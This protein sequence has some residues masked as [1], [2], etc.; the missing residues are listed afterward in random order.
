ME[1]PGELG[2]S[3]KKNSHCEPNTLHIWHESAVSRGL[4]IRNDQASNNN[5]IIELLFC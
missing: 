1:M 4:D 2:S 3:S 5:D